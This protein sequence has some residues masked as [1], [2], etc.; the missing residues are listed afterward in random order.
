MTQHGVRAKKVLD[1][2][3]R[4]KDPTSSCLNLGLVDTDDS[5]LPKPLCTPGSPLSAKLEHLR[6][7]EFGVSYLQAD[8]KYLGCLESFIPEILAVGGFVSNQQC[9]QTPL[10]HA[11]TGQPAMHHKPLNAASC[12]FL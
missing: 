6:Y 12:M 4:G 3:D 2:T 7:L 8:L 9:Q 10:S 11:P 5:V 1:V